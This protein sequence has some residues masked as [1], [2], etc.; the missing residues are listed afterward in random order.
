MFHD[1]Q[2]VPVAFVIP[3][4]DILAVCGIDILPVFQRLLNGRRCRMLIIIVSDAELLEN[5]VKSWVAAHD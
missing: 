3:E 5:L 4:K 1:N 2:V